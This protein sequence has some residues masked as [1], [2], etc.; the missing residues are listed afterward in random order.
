M[1]TK[2]IRHGGAAI[3]VLHSDT[4]LFTDAAS[5]LDLAMTLRYQNGCDRLAVNREALPEDFFRL[6]TGFA[7]EVLQKLVNYRFKF[8]VFGDFSV[9]Q[10]KPLRDFIRESN[11]GRDIFFATDEEQA[12]QKLLTSGADAG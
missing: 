12:I 7:G 5:A 9:F 3:A 1:Q 6:R 2:I 11:R 4:P 10:S 8:A